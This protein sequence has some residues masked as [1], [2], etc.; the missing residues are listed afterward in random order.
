MKN[1]DILK[2]VEETFSEEVYSEGW[3]DFGTSMST[4][5]GKE[6]FMKS[7]SE[8]LKNMSISLP[9]N[10]HTV[11]QL[12]KLLEDLPDDRFIACQVV[13]ADGKAWNM[14]GQFCGQV[15][16]ETIACLTFAHDELK[17]LP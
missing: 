4:L 12:R 5:R 11:G 14:W 10:F 1:E 7:L 15:P 2:I 9:N 6:S 13:A 16:H 3:S 17:T 8:K